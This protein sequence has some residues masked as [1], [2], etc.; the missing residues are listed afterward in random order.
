MTN[1][2]LVILG[3]GSAGLVVASV[4]AQLQAKV[5]LIERDRL[6]GD[7]L[8]HGCVPSKAL[9]EAARAVYQINQ[10][11]KFGIQVSQV[12]IDFAQVMAHVHHA[13]AQIQ[14]HDSPER[15]RS[16]GVEVLFGSGEF[17]NPHAFQ[18][19]DRLLTAN[20]FVIAT[21]SRP[22]IP[23]IS[24]LDQ[25]PYLTNRTIFDLQELPESL[26]ILGGGAIACEL[27][28]AFSRLGTQVTILT[29]GDRLLSKE[30]PEISQ[31]VEAQFRQEQITLVKN[32][33]INQIS[34]HNT[35]IS[36]ATAQANYS[37]THLLLATGRLPNLEGL[38]LSAAQV[39]YSDR[40]I[41]VNAFLQTSNAKI[42]A[43]GD[44]IGQMN[45]THAAGTAA[46]TVAQNALF[47]PSSKMNWQIVPWATFTDPEIA[48]LGLTEAEA[49]AQY[50]QI[51]VLQT[52]YS[53][54]DRAQAAAETTGFAKIICRANGEILGAHLVGAIAGE[55]IHEIKL[56]MQAKLKVSALSSIHI[57]PTLAE[58]V[59]KTALQ[60]SKQNYSQNHRL[61]GFLRQVFDLK[62]K[63]LGSSAILKKIKQS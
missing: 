36:V 38:N 7:C 31:L 39:K 48:H 3:G 59:S 6:G 5:V 24:G 8:W 14:P 51:Q 18:L 27:G 53:Q 17:I 13:I 62:R 49:L 46:A 25:V 29:R 20:A 42:Y 61:Q 54:V 19:Q 40:G 1:Y 56:A 15:F 28:Q 41:L 57:Y 34:A 63:W 22:Q 30:E 23:A 52:P 47:F 50:P 43:C 11:Q 4:A 58:I 32:C 16:L 44:V 55:L 9:I 35:Q 21:G 37:A 60:R 45:F 12:K 26:I 33:Q 10:A 2:N